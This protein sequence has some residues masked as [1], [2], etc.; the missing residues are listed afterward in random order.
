MLSEGKPGPL[1]LQDGAQSAV[2]LSKDGSVVTIDGHSRYQEACYRGNL[3]SLT[4]GYA[5]TTLVAASAIGQTAWNPAVGVANP[6]NSGKNL[7]VIATIAQILS[8]TPTS[9]GIVLG[10]VANPSGITA[11]G[12]NAAV[13]MLT[14]QTGGSIARTFTQT[15]MTGSG[16]AIMLLPMPITTFAGAIAA[17]TPIGLQWDLA[18]MILVPPGT[19]FG[20]SGTLGTATVVQA[21]LI[22]EEIAI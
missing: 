15:A 10:F 16:A 17:S 2:R 14:L 18:G 5:G 12:G 20:I 9:G 7:V 1:V 4:N 22:W 3:W 21:G 13:N 11:A 6:T 19:A 8:G